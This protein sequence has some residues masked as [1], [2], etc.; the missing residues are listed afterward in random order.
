MLINFAIVQIVPGESVEQMIAQITGTAV[1][2]TASFQAAVREK[3][4]NLIV[5]IQQLM[6]ANT[7]EHRV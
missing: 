2:S 1:E 4:L 7:E 3:H 5:I 6:I